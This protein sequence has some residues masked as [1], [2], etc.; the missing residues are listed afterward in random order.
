MSAEQLFISYAHADMR[1]ENWLARLQLYLSQARRSDGIDFWDD[2]RLKPGSRW[3][4]EIERALGDATAAVLLIGPAFLGSSFI[5]DVE[6]PRIL[7]GR[8]TKGTGVFPLIVGYCGY[9]SSPLA[10]YQSVNDLNAPLESL[11]TAEQNKV[12][13]SVAIAVAGHVRSHE[14]R[15]VRVPTSSAPR[16]GLRE[17]VEAL[18]KTR[19]AFRAQ[20]KR[21]DELHT[22]MQHRLGISE[23]LQYERFFVRVFP[24]MNE[25]DTFLFEQI[26]AMTEGPLRDGNAEALA[27]LERH[28]YLLDQ[29][30]RLVDLQQHLVFWLNKYDRVFRRRPDMCL[31]YAGV[32]DGVGYPLGLHEEMEAALAATSTG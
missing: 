15:R 25:D 22:Q 12:L 3:Q 2:S 29:Y 14:P 23:V 11:T 32:E 27:V 30:P 19:T 1:P 31:L 24:Q 13:N 9:A 5:N 6:L 16:D 17:L 18:R 10:P 28:P 7:E 8:R 21:R 26:R 4:D 20:I